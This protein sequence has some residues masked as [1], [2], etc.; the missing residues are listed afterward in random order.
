MDFQMTLCFI[1]VK[2]QGNN[3]DP[4]APIGADAVFSECPKA[5]LAV[6]GHRTGVLIDRPTWLCR[7]ASKGH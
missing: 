3:Y 1:E 5:C 2:H 6:S 7:G 4:E